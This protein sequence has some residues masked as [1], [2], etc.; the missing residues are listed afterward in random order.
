MNALDITEDVIDKLESWSKA[1]PTDIFLEITEEDI[2]Y[3]NFVNPNLSARFFAHVGRHFIDKAFKPA[4]ETLRTLHAENKW[5]NEEWEKTKKEN[6]Y[7]LN[8]N[9]FLLSV[10][11]EKEAEIEALKL[12]EAIKNSKLDCLFSLVLDGLIENASQHTKDM[13]IKEVHGYLHE[14]RKAQEK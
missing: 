10:V 5:L 9:M 2:N 1:Y 14:L 7:L 3:I 6:E 8:K 11:K 4:I 13:A 12:S